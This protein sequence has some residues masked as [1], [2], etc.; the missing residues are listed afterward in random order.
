MLINLGDKLWARQV[1]Q[2]GGKKNKKVYKSL[3]FL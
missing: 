1:S 3:N 2:F